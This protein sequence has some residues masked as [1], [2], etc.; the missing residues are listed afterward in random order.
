MTE[1]GIEEVGRIIREVNAEVVVPR[2][3]AL[4]EGDVAMKG[5]MDPVTVAD[6][7]AERLLTERLAAYLPGSVVVGEEAVSD[8]ASVL[9]AL[10]GPA[11][12]WIIDPIDGTR[13]FVDGSPRFSTLVALAVGGR[14]VASWSYQPVPDVMATARAGH[15]AWVNGERVSSARSAPEAD[16]APVRDVATPMDMWLKGEESTLVDAMRRAG[17]NVGHY[18]ACG[19]EY[20]D[21]AGGK[22]DAMVMTW[23]NS[24]DHAAGL[25]LVAEAGGA[26]VTLDGSEFRLAGGNALPFVVAAH[27]DTAEEIRAILA[28][29]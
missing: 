7:E 13:M 27:R 18:D 25:L 29:V 5:P 10:S 9:A 4:G 3:R 6:R 24:W 8:D 28:A 21:L 23:E 12:V 14:T 19:I 17:V 20:V 2:W 1:E 11:P 26:A 22:L 15:G 16:A